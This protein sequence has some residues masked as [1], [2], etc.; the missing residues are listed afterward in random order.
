MKILLD[1]NMP[2]SLRPLLADDNEVYTT[3]YLGWLDPEH[4]RLL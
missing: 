2:H 4:G 3:A 1:H